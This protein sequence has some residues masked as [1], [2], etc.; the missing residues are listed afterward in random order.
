MKK[1]A[2][3][4]AA[5]TM[6]ASAAQAQ[7]QGKLT[8]KDCKVQIRRATGVS[9][10]ISDRNLSELASISDDSIDALRRLHAFSLGTLISD[11]T[12]AE[13]AIRRHQTALT[14]WSKA[15]VAIAEIDTAS[16]GLI[17]KGWCEYAE[18]YLLLGSAI[19]KRNEAFHL[20]DMQFQ[21]DLA[22]LYLENKRFDL[23]QANLK[24]MLDQK[25]PGSQLSP[26]Q[27]AE[28]NSLMGESFFSIN[29]Y[30][31]AALFFEQSINLMEQNNSYN[32]GFLLENL[33]LLAASQ[34]LTN[35]F[36]KGEKTFEKIA[37]L[38]N[39]TPM[40]SRIA[41]LYDQD[42]VADYKKGNIK[43]A[44]GNAE[45][46][47]A[48]FNARRDELQTKIKSQY[49]PSI[50]LNKLL[51]EH[52]ETEHNQ[53]K[54]MLTLAEVLHS[55]SQLDKALDL[56]TQILAS[57]KNSQIYG[58]LD[59]QVHSNLTRLY[60]TKKEFKLA[61]DHSLTAYEIAEKSFTPLHPSL[62]SAMANLAYV[63]KINDKTDFSEGLYLKLINLLKDESIYGYEELPAYYEYLG[64]IYL[65]KA[66][67]P[68][69]RKFYEL[70]YEK[71]TALQ[72]NKKDPLIRCTKALITVYRK[73]DETNKA[74]EMEKE[75]AKFDSPA[76]KLKTSSSKK[77]KA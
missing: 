14:N 72:G 1:I 7:D 17:K 44:I 31:N 35:S 34:Y 33:Y 38:D 36:L 37:Q 76:Q 45:K 49:G 23:T 73:L 21:I 11:V 26:A 65:A 28:A 39:T 61:E 48:F 66:N 5:C 9:K 27:K 6:T 43:D 25:N 71:N 40:I 75:L 57:H 62:T 55:Q 15:D 70:A 13:K 3:F 19:A 30:G 24:L 56:Y 29:D 60:L 52:Q 2:Y 10:D 64:E 51:R 77:S 74:R 58:R 67:F 18:S 42:V 22:K 68:D 63:Y 54:T 53:L 12:T 46:R 16:K 50:E 8:G 4:L 47:L 69:A 20:Q 59:F 41:S 32:K